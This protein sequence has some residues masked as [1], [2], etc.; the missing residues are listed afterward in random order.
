MRDK[1]NF[2]HHPRLTSGGGGGGGGGKMKF[3][4]MQLIEI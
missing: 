4:I 2:L 1:R 3:I